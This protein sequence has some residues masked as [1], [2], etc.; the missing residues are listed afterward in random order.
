M[1]RLS[2]AARDRG[3]QRDALWTPPVWLFGLLLL[4][5]C[6]LVYIVVTAPL[7]PFDVQIEQTVQAFHP[8]W[9]DSL[10]GAISWV[11]F[12][13]ESI[14][15]DG[16]IV[17][18]IFLTGARW[19]AICSA[20]AAAG[21]AGVWFLIIALV[22]RP[23]PTPDL[24]RVTAEI[25]FGSFPSGHVMNITAFFGFL[26][27]LA[28]VLLEPGWARRLA[29]GVCLVLIAAIGYARIYSGEHWPTDVLA[30]YVL[31]T[32]WLWLTLRLYRWGRG[33]WGA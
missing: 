29:V 10:T 22:H 27:C 24:V 16:M 7:P 33:R 2:H 8:P 9:L 26:A 17:L 23:R 32:V 21:S 14:V 5:F 30:G 6:V 18:A 3:L 12:P 11:G 31:G 19:A 4:I 25:Q 1:G 15:I 20:F 13:P 28:V